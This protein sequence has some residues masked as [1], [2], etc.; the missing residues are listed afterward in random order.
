MEVIYVGLG[1]NIRSDVNVVRAVELL[2]GRLRLAATSTFFTTEPIGRPEHEWY[3]NGV[4]SADTELE[5]AGVKEI[6][7]AVER[8]LGRTRTSDR[9]APRT[10]DLD[11]LLHGVRVVRSGTLV[12]PHPDLFD[13]PFLAAALLELAPRLIVPGTGRALA[14]LVSVDRGE[15]A[16]N[17]RLTREV[18]RILSA[19]AS[20]MTRRVEE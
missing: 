13:R 16:V 14:E 5:P 7:A 17:E 3:A 8:E 2:K 10:I 1:S 15:L 4:V 20:E 9:Y 6:L 11:L 19:P 18:R 12:I